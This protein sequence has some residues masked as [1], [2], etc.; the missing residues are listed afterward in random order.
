MFLPYT[1]VW[2]GG[3]R[4]RCQ[5]VVVREY[6]AAY[7]VYNDIETTN[8]CLIKPFREYMADFV[9]YSQVGIH[10]SRCKLRVLAS[11]LC[12]Q[13]L[14]PYKRLGSPHFPSTLNTSL[15]FVQLYE[16][17]SEPSWKCW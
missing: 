4:E 17:G 15:I 2:L 3:V 13:A 7:S 16:C 5:S 8:L 12:R 11:R 1:D 14:V 9:M 10:S 6:Q